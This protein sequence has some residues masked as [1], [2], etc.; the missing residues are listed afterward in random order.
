[1][2]LFLILL[3]LVAFLYSSVGHGGA[4][5]YLALMGLYFIAP[6]VMKPSALMLNI[7]VSLIAFLQYIQ[8][9]SANK[10]LVLLLI[11]GSVP[12]SFIG[13]R[14]ML[15]ILIYQKALG[16]LL[17][18]PVIHLFGFLGKDAPEFK[19]P[20]PYLAISIG[21]LIGF[22]SGVIGIGGGVLLSPI[23]L[24]LG[25]ASI[26]QTALISS[27]FIFINSIS[28]MVGLLSK[29]I[30]IT[31][32]IYTWIA[33]AIIGGI[34]GSYFGAKKFNSNIFKRVLAVVLAIASIKLIIG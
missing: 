7:I 4:S 1:M 10:K 18:F 9:T 25:W 33:I 26:K 13:A 27:L 29:G 31:P 14:I 20:N 2:T 28:G 3:F 6:E 15:D 24:L 17:L 34:A 8:N 16:V 11:I 32:T 5:G 22:I 12:A 21:V 23:I 30:S 19:T